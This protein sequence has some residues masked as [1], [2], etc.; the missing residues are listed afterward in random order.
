MLK[1]ISFSF[2][3]SSFCGLV[4]YMLTE[5]IGGVILGLENF[6]AL[7]PEYVSLF[8]SGTLAMEVAIVF[9]GLIGAAFS[10]ATFI[11]EKIEIGFVLQNVI[12]FCLT[13]LVWIPVVCF[14]WQLYRYPSAL[15]S[16]IGGF[17]LTYVIMSV[18]G[19]NITKKEIAQINAHLAEEN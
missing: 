10:A 3:I 5:L 9:H 15:F 7:T 17:V 14:V 4:V 12:Y 2:V 1:R 8:P 11:Y 16:T 13:G 6:S 18:V 19:Y